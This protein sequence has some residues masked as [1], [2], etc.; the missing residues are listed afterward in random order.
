MNTMNHVLFLCILSLSI[1][2]PG[3]FS[4]TTTSSIRERSR[5]RTPPASRFRLPN[6]DE[7]G[8]LI[9]PKCRYCPRPFGAD[10]KGDEKVGKRYCDWKCRKDWEKA[11][12]ERR[13]ERKADAESREITDLLKATRIVEEM[14]LSKERH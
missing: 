5:S 8:K 1:F 4:T 10:W 6:I 7:N 9:Y 3:A 11:E 13:K 2:V 12:L 14:L